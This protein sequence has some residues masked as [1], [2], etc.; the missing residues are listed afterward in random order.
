M[1]GLQKI[2]RSTVALMG[3]FVLI[4]FGMIE[5][6][7]SAE[8]TAGLNPLSTFERT[9]QEGLAFSPGYDQRGQP[10]NTLSFIHI[11]TNTGSVMDHFLIKASTSVTW[12]LE[13]FSNGDLTNAQQISLTLGAATT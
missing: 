3:P 1:S 8:P 13:L 10:G 9:A 2:V 6:R 12:P 11:L 5:L 7:S 4:I